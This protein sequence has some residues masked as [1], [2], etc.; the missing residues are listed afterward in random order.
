MF[1]VSL[2]NVAVSVCFICLLFQI[3]L[4][5]LISIENS[6]VNIINSILSLLLHFEHNKNERK[7]KRLQKNYSNIV[8]ENSFY[9][10]QLFFLFSFKWFPSYTHNHSFTGSQNIVGHTKHLFVSKRIFSFTINKFMSASVLEVFGVQSC[11][12]PSLF[13]F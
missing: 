4:L 1:F 3:F 9:F 8:Y 13:F 11:S 7:R 12:K 6:I 5:R 10:A 2:A